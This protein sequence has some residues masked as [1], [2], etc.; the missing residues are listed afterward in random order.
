MGWFALA[1]LLAAGFCGWNARQQG[2]R[3][4]ILRAARSSSIAELEDLRAA[5]SADIGGGAFREL[6]KLE[7]DLVCE[8][9]LQAPWSG[10]ACVAFI[11]TVTHL[12]QERVEEQSTDSQGRTTTTSRWEQREQQ[13]SRLERRCPFRLRQGERELPIDPERA[14]LEFESVHSSLDSDAAAPGGAL[15][16][17]QIRSLGLRREEEVFRSGGSIFVVAEA[18]DAGGE[19]RLRHPEG[20]GLFLVRREGEQRVLA[21]TVQ[22]R[23]GWWIGT[24]VLVVVALGLLVAAL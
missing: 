5:V 9:P 19:L 20:E 18:S 1:L 15:Q 7:G 12:Y 22:Q 23:R 3:L 10:L 14:E 21:R 13:V 16:R 8:E 4:R 2:R 6:V 17:S 11:D 24:G